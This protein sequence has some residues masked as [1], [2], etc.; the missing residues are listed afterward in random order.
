MPQSVFFKGLYKFCS[1]ITLDGFK[2]L[3]NFC[4]GITLDGNKV[5]C[6]QKKSNELK[7]YDLKIWSETPT[8]ELGPWLGMKPKNQLVPWLDV[9]CPAAGVFPFLKVDRMK[10]QNPA[11]FPANSGDFCC[12]S[13]VCE[14]SGWIR[15]N[16][17]AAERL[18]QPVIFRLW[19]NLGW[20]WQIWVLYVGTCMKVELLI[21]LSGKREAQD[22]AALYHG[23]G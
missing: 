23:H 17:M 4:S 14:A 7:G 2:G 12:F 16:P 6:L 15:Q 13:C 8:N 22:K 18:V 3:Y 11:F 10:K 19:P 20:T 9:D 21:T 1:G 5:C